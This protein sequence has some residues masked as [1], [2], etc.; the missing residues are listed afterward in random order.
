MFLKKDLNE[1]GLQLAIS[2]SSHSLYIGLI[3]ENFILSGNVPAVSIL[4]QRNVMGDTIIGLLTIRILAVI[5][6][7]PH[8]ITS[9]S[10]QIH[11]RSTSHPHHIT[12]TS[13]HIHITSHP[14]HITSTSD[15]HH[16]RSTSHHI[17]IRSTSHPSDFVLFN[18]L[19]IFFHFISSCI[20]LL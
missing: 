7:H 5:S 18:S 16:I 19:I 20:F 8:H 14:H 13:H 10:H 4:L 9:T 11:I 12:S 15:P 1:K 17:H 3:S 2:V 6:S